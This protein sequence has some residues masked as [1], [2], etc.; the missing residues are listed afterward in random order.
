MPVSA[1]A[2]VELR[3]SMAPSIGPIQ[4]VQPMA[5]ATPSTNAAV[6]RPPSSVCPRLQGLAFSNSRISDIPGRQPGTASVIFV[7][8][9]HALLPVGPEGNHLVVVLPAGFHAGAALDHA[10]H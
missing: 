6:G 9:E 3:A 2:W 10:R 4:G 7:L 5:N 8:A 1:L